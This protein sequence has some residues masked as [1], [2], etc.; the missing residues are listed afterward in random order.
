M[1]KLLYTFLAVSII[2]AACKKE[3]DEVVTPVAPSIVGV[4]TPTSVSVTESMSVTVMGQ[5]VDSFDTTFTEAPA[6]IGM[7]GD[8]EFTADGNMYNDGDT[9][10]YTYSGN[11]L[12]VTED[13]ETETRSCTVTSTSLT[14]MFSETET[15][16]EDY[17]GQEAT[18][19]E[20][21]DMTLNA[22]RQ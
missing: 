19:T 2:F 15:Y 17:M 11:V 20:S 4:W 10:S 14:V 6:D 12:T 5:I 13:G 3:E 8:V 1:K 21:W 18:I 9:N 22:T 7:D 16:T